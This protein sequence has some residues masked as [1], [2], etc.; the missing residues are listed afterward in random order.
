M[1]LSN[2][3]QSSIKAMAKKSA[4]SKQKK[5]GM[6][7]YK[8][9]EILFKE[10]EIASS[11]FIIQKGQIRL[12]LPKGKGFVEIAILRAGEVIGEMAYF[13]EQNRK[14]SCSAS[15]IVETQVI[16]ISFAAFGKTISN[17]NP[18]FKTII[19][20]L[21]DRLRKSNT[22]IKELENNSVGFGKGGKVAEYKFFQNSDI[23]RLFS[24]FGLVF[25]SDGT[26]EGIYTQ[27]NFKKIKFYAV[28]IFNVQEIKLEEF[29]QLLKRTHIME[30]VKDENNLPNILRVKDVG[31][32]KSLM[33]F[34][35]TQRIL[36]D[37]KQLKISKRCEIFLGGIKDQIEEKNVKTTAENVEVDISKV[38]TR[39]KH[40]NVDIAE[41]DLSD[42]ITA[43]IC[44]DIIVDTGNKLSTTVNYSQLY[45]LYPAIV[46]KNEITKINDAKTKTAGN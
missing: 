16:E 8:P 38:L 42:A 37:E 6:K 17:L 29:I 40:G 23:I 45:K 41:E 18:W 20:T 32:L 28:D 4:E 1:A 21:A 46:L 14:R 19:N 7:T 3:D 44:E 22:K 24:I 35:N 34:F 36:A 5:S 30:A 31:I 43:N 10:K 15:A 25:G 9:G 27:V 2:N 26:Q 39:F 13:D 11:L 33:I 12:Y